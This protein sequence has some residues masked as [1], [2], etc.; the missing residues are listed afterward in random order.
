MRLSR[1]CYCFLIQACMAL[2]L[3]F[4]SHIVWALDADH[5][6]FRQ[7][8]ND[9]DSSIGEALCITQDKRGFMW[10]GGKEGLARF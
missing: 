9:S 5:I 1:V 7:L 4:S 8:L 6:R 3:S 2:I 10:F